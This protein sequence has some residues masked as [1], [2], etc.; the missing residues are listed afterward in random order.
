MWWRDIKTVRWQSHRCRIL[1][2]INNL[3]W[4]HHTICLGLLQSSTLWLLVLSQHAVWQIVFSVCWIIWAINLLT[5]SWLC[6]CISVYVVICVDLQTCEPQLPLVLLHLW[7]NSL[8]TVSAHF[9]DNSDW[10]RTL[11][12]FCVEKENLQFNRLPV[13][14]QSTCCRAVAAS[15][16][17][18][19][20]PGLSTPHT[21]P[22]M[23]ARVCM[24]YME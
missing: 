17:P 18:S 7:P 12:P 19:G 2:Q 20:G 9:P 4:K 21:S 8:L 23:S 22:P 10:R 16:A 3:R 6:V 5:L 15:G 1:C 11:Q 24:P 13:N 14:V